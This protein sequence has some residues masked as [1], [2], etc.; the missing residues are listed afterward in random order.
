[1]NRCTLDMISMSAMLA[2]GGLGGWGE[3]GGGCMRRTGGV[4]AAAVSTS[5]NF[6]KL[7]KENTIGGLGKK[8]GGVHQEL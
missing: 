2:M 1:M 3:E 6:K 8:N 4:S 7:I 5:D